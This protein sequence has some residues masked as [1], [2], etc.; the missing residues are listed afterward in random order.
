MHRLL[1]AAVLLLSFAACNPNYPPPDELPAEY[2]ACD[3]AEDCVIVELG[4]C[5]A[6]NGGEA[7]SV[8]AD[9]A[10]AVADEFAEVCVGDTSCTLIGCAPLETTCNAGVCGMEQGEFE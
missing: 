6:C 10:A 9:Q 5:D 7:R 8:A 3:T 1:A 2:T 4:C